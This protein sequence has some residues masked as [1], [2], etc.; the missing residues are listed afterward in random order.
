[1]AP[2]DANTMAK[3]VGGMADNLLTSVFRAWDT[4]GLFDL[5]PSVAAA[6]NHSSDPNGSH[7]TSSAEYPPKRIVLAPA[8]NTAM[9]RHPVTKKHLAVLEGEWGI[10]VW[11]WEEKRWRGKGRGWME[12][13]RPVEKELACGDVG[14]GAMRPWEEIVGVIRERLEERVKVKRKME[15][16]SAVEDGKEA[17]GSA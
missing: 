8:M 3:V 13:L 9:W 6:I 15:M 14:D 10:P 4:T 2:L 7:V 16:E 12:V 1:M 17:S 5:P 11:D